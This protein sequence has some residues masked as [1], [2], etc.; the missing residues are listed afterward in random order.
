MK[1]KKKGGALRAEAHGVLFKIE[2]NTLSLRNPA[3]GWEKCE[4]NANIENAKQ[5]AENIAELYG[6]VA[7]IDAKELAYRR[8]QAQKLAVMPP[9]EKAI[10]NLFQ[11]WQRFSNMERFA[12]RKLKPGLCYIFDEFDKVLAEEKAHEAGG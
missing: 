7:E 3:G 1:W 10:R 2:E 9:E 12:A 6:K 4:P 11:V 8:Q 5:R